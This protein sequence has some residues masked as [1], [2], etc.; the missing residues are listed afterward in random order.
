[1]TLVKSVYHHHHPPTTEPC[2]LLTGFNPVI[3]LFMLIV[4]NISFTTINFVT[5]SVIMFSSA[6]KFL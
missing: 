5:L 6:L 3:P 4:P 2:S 1:M